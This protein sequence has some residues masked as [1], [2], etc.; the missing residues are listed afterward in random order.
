M[1]PHLSITY[2]RAMIAV[3]WIL[4]DAEVEGNELA[5]KEAKTA[6]GKSVL[7]LR[8]WRPDAPVRGQLSRGW[9]IIARGAA[10]EEVRKLRDKR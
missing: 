7:T 10:T 2:L 8:P 9:C 1:L 5:D 4:V 3:A 6:V